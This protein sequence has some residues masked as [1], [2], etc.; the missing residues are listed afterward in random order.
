MHFVRRRNFKAFALPLSAAAVLLMPAMTLAEAEATAGVDAAL[1]QEIKYIDALSANGYVDFTDAVIEAAKKKWPKAKGVL[2]TATVRAEL[3]AGKQEAV[4]AKIN[5]RPDKDS[6]DTWLQK[7]ELA[8]SY[9]QYSKYGEADKLYSEFFKKFP[10]VDAAAKMPYITAAYYYI[11][12]LNKIDRSKD[13]LPIYKLAME[14]APTDALQKDLR[15]QYLQ[16]LLVQSEQMPAGKERDDTIKQAEEI[17]NKMV[18]VQDSYF[19]DA[20]NG[21]AHAKML[22]GDVKGAQEMIQEYVEM[23]MQIHE[24]IRE[25]DPDGSLGILRMSPLPQCRYLLGKMLYDKAKEEI[26]KGGAAN[27][28]TIKNLLLGERDPATKK[29]NGQG[30]FNHLVNVYMNFP[31]SQSASLAGDFV[32]EITKIIQSRYN[33]TLKVNVSPEQRAKVRQQQYVQA[34]VA[35]D[36]GDW[37][38][39]ID[40]YTKT[41]SQYGLNREALPAIKKMIEATIR[42]GVKGGQLD[43]YSKLQAET[44]TAALAEGFSGMSGEINNQAGDTVSNVATL[45]KELGLAAMADS[46]YKYFFKYYPK[47]P[48]A[49]ALQKKMADDKVKAGDA[50]GAEELYCIIRDAAVSES[51]RTERMAALM[52]LRSLYIPSGIAPNV[53][54]EL[55]AAEDL[56]KHF[57]GIARPGIYA[58]IAQFYLADAY[59]HQAE[60]LRKEVKDS[61]NDKK[62]TASYAKA[63]QIYNALAK[64]LDKEDSKYVSA[65]SERKDANTWLD[66]SLYQC[67][68]CIQRLPTGGDAKKEKALKAKAAKTFED[69]MKRFPKGFNA[70]KAMLQIGTLQAATG[71][72]EASRATLAKLAK[73]FPESE[74]AKNS[75]PL[76][77]DS[78]FKMGM[79]GEATNTYKQ[80]FST[81]GNY[82]P[83]QYQ[84]AA[85]KLLDAGETKLALDACDCILK[86][87]NNKSYLPKAMLLRTKALLADKQAAAAYKQVSEL[88]DQYGNTTVAV[89]AN[90]AMLEVIGAQI[91]NANTFEE[92]N[93]LIGKAKK[94]VTFLSSQADR[95]AGDNPAAAEA[96]KVRLNL[97]VA[98]VARQAY[99]AEKQA[100]SERVRTA[101]GS[102]LNAYRQAM[103]AGS[104][105]VTD[106]AVAP[107]VQKAYKGYLEL[108]R[109]LAEMATDATEKQDT[110]RDIVDLGTEYQ[111]KFPEGTYKADV[112]N[113]V[114]QA[115]IELGE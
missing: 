47:H 64:E 23:L 16:A 52:G 18:W 86:A 82:T 42:S 27:E 89:D 109:A 107:N 66:N 78:L 105:P 10:K 49:V 79:K 90:H 111:E 95:N 13:T 22:R 15:S 75:I 36:G 74:E 20:I 67:G 84:T 101:L 5:A 85:E 71:D 4:L 62:I 69:Y 3:A 14:Q 88:M 92:R 34:N 60:A 81:G 63:A 2:E 102:A 70:S 43:P 30:A 83:A 72:I 8:A 1:E 38:K 50:A 28:D 100:N 41:I 113:A 11:A 40:A 80:M 37:E 99:E 7:L 55:K 87:K 6:L 25:Q 46:T 33:T 12:M 94:A 53:E 91:L 32:E 103:F 77:A 68:V 58:A 17:A 19:G 39:A 108:T 93:E 106:P 104:L 54:K 21:L 26:A 73:D 97:A 96:E 114:L 56:A 65:A 31:E 59:R 110:L 45:Y 98:D 112:I 115:K 61:S 35:F 57:E 48:Q 51:Q 29:R 76:L 44:L 9:F 24:Q